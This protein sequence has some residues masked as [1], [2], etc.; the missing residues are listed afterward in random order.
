MGDFKIQINTSFIVPFSQM[1]WKLEAFGRDR[2]I[3]GTE[4][5]YWKFFR[6]NE[7]MAKIIIGCVLLSFFCYK[8]CL[9]ETRSRCAGPRDRLAPTFELTPTFARSR[10][11]S[12]SILSC[13]RAVHR[14][15]TL[16]GIQTIFN[17]FFYGIGTFDGG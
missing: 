11:F 14:P 6:E 1:E 9:P 8:G 10:V 12:Y 2:I 17:P 15:F 13:F 7:Y 5:L 16:L 4:S 3:I